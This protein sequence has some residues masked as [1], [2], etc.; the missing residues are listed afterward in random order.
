MIRSPFLA[1]PLTGHCVGAWKL[2]WLSWRSYW[3]STL[4]PGVLWSHFFPQNWQ[5]TASITFSWPWLSDLWSLRSLRSF[6]CVNIRD[7]AKVCF[8]RSTRDFG[9]LTAGFRLDLKDYYNGS[10]TV[11]VLQIDGYALRERARERERVLLS[12]VNVPNEHLPPC[13]KR[14]NNARLAWISFVSAGLG[15]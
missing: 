3:D 11:V 15:A 14:S 6:G 13:V 1:V 10:T 4:S 7:M 2:T 9:G 12:Y 5:C 8:N